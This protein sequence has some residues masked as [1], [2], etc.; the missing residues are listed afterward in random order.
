[1]HF[2]A[3][4]ATIYKQIIQKFNTDASSPPKQMEIKLIRRTWMENKH[5]QLQWNPLICTPW[6]P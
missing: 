5:T 4:H 1:M 2:R 3:L 6:G